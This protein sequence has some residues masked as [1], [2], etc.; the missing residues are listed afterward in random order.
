MATETI[1][2]MN[3]QDMCIVCFKPPEQGMDLIPHH[4]TYFPQLIAFVHY[5]CHQK[6]H[7]PDN[8]IKHLIQYEDGDSKKF[9]E[10]L[11]INKAKLC[12]ECGSKLPNHYKLCRYWSE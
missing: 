7:D 1:E 2:Y 4:I 5:K 12:N 11:N 8:P 10:I 9:Y 3:S 6:I